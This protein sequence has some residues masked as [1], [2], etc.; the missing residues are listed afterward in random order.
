MKTIIIF[1]SLLFFCAFEGFTIVI[2]VDGSYQDTNNNSQDFELV[3]QN[4]K[5]ASQTNT[6]QATSTVNLMPPSTPEN[7]IISSQDQFT[8]ILSWNH[9]QDPDTPQNQIQYILQATSATSV[10]T[11]TST[12]TNTYCQI[13]LLTNLSLP[14]TAALH[15][16]T[17]YTFA[18]TAFD[19]NLYSSTTYITN[20]YTPSLPSPY[21]NAAGSFKRN[22]LDVF[23]LI[24]WGS[25]TIPF[26]NIAGFNLTYYTSPADTTTINI[27]RSAGIGSFEFYTLQNLRF[28]TEYWLYLEIIN[29]QGK[30]SAKTATVKAKTLP[31]FIDLGNGFIKDPYLN[32]QFPKS[33]L[34]EL[35]MFGVTTTQ[36]GADLF[37]QA[38]YP[39]WRLPQYKELFALSQYPIENTQNGLYWS[40][41]RTPVSPGYGPTQYQAQLLDFNTHYIGVQ[42]YIPNIQEAYNYFLPVQGALLCAPTTIIDNGDGTFTDTC[43]KKMWT[44]TLTSFGGGVQWQSAMNMAANTTTSGY[45][46]WRLPSVLELVEVANSEMYFG[47]STHWALTKNPQ[48]PN[49]AWVVVMY[50][51]RGYTDAVN[52]LIA[53]GHVRLVRDIIPAGIAANIDNYFPN[54][55]NSPAMVQMGQSTEISVT[56]TNTGNTAW[57]FIAG[58]SV[59]DSKGAKVADYEKTLDTA[60]NPGQQTTV[61]WNHIVNKAGDYWLQFAVWK[62]K[63]YITE[64]LLD[65]KPVPSQRLIVGVS[66]NR[67][68]NR[69]TNISPASGAIGV[70]LTASLQSSPFSDPDSGDTHAASQWQITTTTGNYSAPVFDSGADSQHLTQITLSSLAFNTTYY[71][72]VRHQDNHGAW[73]EW[74]NETLFTTRSISLLEKYAPVLYFH[75]EE[76]F[77]PWGISSM[78]GKADLSKLNIYTSPPIGEKILDKP[79]SLDNLS[80]YNDFLFYL[81][82]NGYIPYFSVPNKGVWA[83]YS[84]YIVYDRQYETAGATVLQYWFFYPFN[85]WDNGTSIPGNQHEGDWEM[86][87]ILYSKEKNEPEQLTASYHHSGKSY[88]WNSE[89]SKIDGT[90][91]KIFVAKGGHGLWANSG[92]HEVGKTWQKIA[93]WPFFRHIALK[94]LTSEDGMVLYPKGLIP[95]FE[96]GYQLRDISNEPN[97]VN[98]KGIWGELFLGSSGPQSPGLQEKWKDP[99]KWS[100]KPSQSWFNAWFGSPGHLHIYDRYG[101]HVGLTDFGGV[102]TNIPGTYF[103]MPSSCSWDSKEYVWINTSED[104][105][106]EIKATGSGSFDLSFNRYLQEEDITMGAAYTNVQITE[107]TIATVDISMANPGFI[108]EIDLDGDRIV[109]KVQNPAESTNIVHI[110][111]EMGWNFISFPLQPLNDEP[112]VIFSS[113]NTKCNS[114][115]TYKIDTGWSVYTPDGP[116]NLGKIEQGKG[117]WIEMNQSGILVIQGTNTGHEPIYLKGGQWN[118]VGYSSLFAIPVEKVVLSMPDGTCIYTYNAE[119]KMWLRYIKGGPSVFNNLAQLEPKRGYYIYVQ[120]DCLFNIN[121]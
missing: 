52:P 116:N 77:Y 93:E 55:P 65:K 46:N 62:D 96:A 14:A 107:D 89:V 100:K 51:M 81:D 86:V 15:P 82:L 3:L 26:A 83:D 20:F 63:P 5:S 28:N 9:S 104:L 99:I 119:D 95:P 72:H 47:L 34:T 8:F 80:K 88:N 59:W 108:M 78:L 75:P 10:P 40:A 57:Q 110:P 114:V 58:A 2:T 120:Q 66:A 49:R 42:H 76:Q 111:L 4:K 25:D 74:S 118:L 121:P 102:E 79:I 19:G 87:Q 11:I 84:E 70:P 101:N 91:P 29:T 73:S 33:A 36:E 12:T 60:L 17:P 30:V 32:I 113:I 109:D 53:T 45:T 35:S 103:Y 115:W 67:S 105:K 39:G 56:F 71:W 6:E 90:H 64:N 38:N 54:D 50:Y 7:F 94:D 69:P 97:W 112:S 13:D 1:I 24:P 44:E 16:N 85:D 27:P 117:Y 106:I 92:A 43:H 21:F 23:W 37:L 41:N 22:E 18:L 31:N 48:D 61:S 68:P 98:W